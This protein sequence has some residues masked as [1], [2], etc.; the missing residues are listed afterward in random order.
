MKKTLLFLS[1]LAGS[2]L[3]FGQ[4][5]PQNNIKAGFTY[6]LFGSGDLAGFNYYNEY[7]RRLNR[8]LTFAPSLHFGYGAKASDYLRSTKA[9]FSVDPNVFISPMRFEKSKIRLGVGPSLRFLSDSHPSSFGLLFNGGTA[10]PLD[11]DYLITPITYTRPLNYWTI[12]Y[13][14]LLEAELHFTRH[15]LVGTRASFQNYA[16]GETALNAGLNV[17]YRF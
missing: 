3:V 12:G 5:P 8:F 10:L 6:I 9:S 1:L 14:L 7:N 17:G 2:N 11:K 13:T 15:W 4:N 16:S